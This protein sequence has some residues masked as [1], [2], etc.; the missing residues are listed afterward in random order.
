M[1]YLE[2]CVSELKAA[3]KNCKTGDA[4]IMT[5]NAP[6]YDVSTARTSPTGVEDDEEDEDEEMADDD[7]GAA[8]TAPASA[9]NTPLEH[10]L[11]RRYT[12]STAGHSRPS[13]SPAILPSATTSPLFTRPSMSSNQSFSNLPSPA[14]YAQQQSRQQARLPSLSLASPMLAAQRGGAQPDNRQLPPLANQRQEQTHSPA[15]QSLPAVQL[16]E[17][18]EATASALLML[19]ADKRSWTGRGMSVK[20]L[21]SSQ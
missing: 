19:T 11:D 4:A 16:A 3:H 10:P 17:N 13:V 9:A 8:D 14:F 5:R 21:L 15:S 18:D 2:S 7:D 12:N 1:R 20:D 6:S